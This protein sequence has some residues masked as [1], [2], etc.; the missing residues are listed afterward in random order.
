MQRGFIFDLDGTIYIENQ[1][2]PG[3]FETVQQ[4]IQRGDKVIYFTNKSIE[5]IA[6]Y[7]QKLRALGIEV[8]N[9]QVVNSN[10]LVARYLE[11]NISLQ[12]KVMVIGENPL[13]EEIEKKGIKCTWDP[14]ETSYV[15]IGWDREFTYEKLN[16]VFQAWKKGA[17]IIAT[18]PDR[19]CPVENGE[20]PDCGAMIGALEGATGEKIEL[21]LGKP[22][23][24]AAQF[25]TQEL[26]QLP[27]EQCYMVGDRIE[28]D[29]KM[30]IE[31]GMHTVLVLTGITTKKMINQSQYHPEFVVDSVRDIIDTIINLNSKGKD[32][33]KK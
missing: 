24:Q 8:K 6:T 11:K 32:P 30:G 27:P 23:V 19:T 1:L 12:A 31:S 29:I 22:S 18:N 16:L 28:T 10:Y 7:V 17:T 21:I 13:I 2:I 20:I 15:I 5:S 26:M 33:R 9:N 3:V 4:L 25:I 14:L